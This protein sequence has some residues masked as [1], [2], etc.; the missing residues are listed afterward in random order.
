[1]LTTSPWR[2]AFGGGAEVSAAAAGP[3]ID[4][5]LEGVVLVEMAMGP[6]AI[7]DQVV[8]GDAVVAEATDLVAANV[9]AGVIDDPAGPLDPV[10][11]AASD[12]GVRVPPNPGTRGPTV[13]S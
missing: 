1:L 12:R 2:Y 8:L 10:A 3:D 4:P 13:G 6:G 11:S 5:G 9:E 7:A